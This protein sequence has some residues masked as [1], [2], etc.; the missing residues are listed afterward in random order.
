MVGGAVGGARR[1][2]ASGRGVVRRGRVVR[3]GGLG[4]GISADQ[5]DRCGWQGNKYKRQ[6][7][8]RTEPEPKKGSVGSEHGFSK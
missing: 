4:A 1:Q 7:W 3:A 8:L 2:G 5:Q 6:W